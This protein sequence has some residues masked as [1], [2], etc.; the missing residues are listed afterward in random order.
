MNTL[1]IQFKNWKQKCEKIRYSLKKMVFVIK[2]PNVNCTEQFLKVAPVTSTTPHHCTAQQQR[3]NNTQNY[4][5]ILDYPFTVPTV[6]I[7]I[8]GNYYNS[9]LFQN[10]LWINLRCWHRQQIWSAPQLALWHCSGSKLMELECLQDLW[11]NCFRSVSMALGYFPTHTLI[12]YIKC[13]KRGFANY[14]RERQC[15]LTLNKF[16]LCFA[17]N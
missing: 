4:I 5:S 2:S 14:E 8:S 16:A 10:I 15:C 7:I 6:I 17:E 11:I 1:L 13:D 3:T 9:A 12:F